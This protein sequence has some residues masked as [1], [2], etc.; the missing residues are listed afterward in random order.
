MLFRDRLD[1]SLAPTLKLKS[2]LNVKL[3]TCL[4][5]APAVLVAPA[6]VFA[7]SSGD[8]R[9]EQKSAH[10]G[11]D[12][13][14]FP[15]HSVADSD[16]VLPIVLEADDV[17]SQGK[18]KVTLKGKAFVAQGR[19]SV[20]GEKIVYDRQNDT[21]QAQGSVELRSVAGDLIS[22][23]SVDLDVN[24]SIGGAE[25]AN[26]K[27]AKRGNI[28]EETNGVAVQSRGSAKTVSIEGEDFVRMKNAS[29]TTCVEG[30]DDFFIKAS[31]LEL[32]RATGIGTAKNARFIFKGVPFFYFPRVSFPITDK[33]KT[34]FLFPTLGTDSE[35]GFFFGTPWYWNIAP[36]ADATITPKVFTDRG[37]QLGVEARHIS[38]NSETDI[39][40]EFLPSDSEYVNDQGETDQSRHFIAID[41]EQDFT[42]ELS[43]TID[44]NDLSDEDYFRDFRTNINAFSSTYVPSEARL[45]Y[46]E[47]NWDLRLRTV[48]YEVIDEDATEPFDLLPQ[49]TFNNR[50]DDIAGTGLNF[51][52][53]A[54]ATNFKRSDEDS[55]SRILVKPSIERPIENTWGYIKPKLEI[56]FASFSQDDAESRTA[57][58]FSLDSGLFLERRTSFQ[59]NKG[60]QT[61]EPR[62]FYVNADADSSDSNPNF[63][64]SALDFNNF[65]DLFSTTGFTGG[66]D[67]ADGQRVALALA[68]RYYDE[69]GNQRFKG[70]IGQVYFIDD[71]TSTDDDGVTTSRDKSDFLVDVDYQVTDLL[72]VGAFL[73]YGEIATGEGDEVRNANFNIEYQ[74]TSDNFIKFA[75]RL[76]KNLRSSTADDG[77]I[78]NTVA[79]TSQFVAEASWKVSSQWRLFGTQ[80]Y[81]I[82]DSE[83]IQTRLGAEYD[84][85]CWSLTVT[86]DRLRK[87]DD[88]FRNAI[89]AQIE[90]AGL[91]RIK[92]GFQ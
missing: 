76:N 77:S 42:D 15:N 33:R 89:F 35:S 83:S 55:N 71:L 65:N 70:Q 59:G 14:A 10:C 20:A 60:L 21:V 23:D 32:D 30:Q 29:Y 36:N 50:Y 43:L 25:N 8:D 6:S 3:I 58:I 34:G 88:E 7:A 78:V 81:D 45:D 31:E 64:T 27:L 26:F 82:D 68:T 44:I 37:V 91:G 39:N 85:C 63:D 5:M 67:V 1:I 66:D 53:E 75:Y 73:G 48:T 11:P 12:I 84:A 2:S 56:D 57:P 72:N 62:V 49:L 87:S 54:S 4:M 69:N 46:V 52:T 61:L 80:R 16:G 92:T 40:A 28:T 13:L 41:H 90:F 22:A 17:E 38:R 86:G 9:A 24:T 79:D 19:Q 18:E 51:R 74:P 47:D